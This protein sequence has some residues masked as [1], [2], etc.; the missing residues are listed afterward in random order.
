MDKDLADQLEAIN[1]NIILARKG[2][3]W[4]RSLIHGTMTGLGSVMGVIIALALLGW[5]L[6]IIGVIPALRTE[7]EQWKNLIQRAQQQRLP[8]GGSTQQ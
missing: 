1:K 8:S 6:N 3:P 7:T 2:M 5:I 4:W